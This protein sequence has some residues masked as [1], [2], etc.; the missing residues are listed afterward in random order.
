MTWGCITMPVSNWSV[1]EEIKRLVRID[2]IKDME[3]DYQFLKEN[4]D[5]G[6]AT[7][8]REPNLFYKQGKSKVGAQVWQCKTCKKKTNLQHIIK[9]EMTF[10]LHL[11][12]TY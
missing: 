11:Q 4:C 6:D 12:E 1:A 2:T 7:P 10:Y 9:R 3:P 8:F 5:N